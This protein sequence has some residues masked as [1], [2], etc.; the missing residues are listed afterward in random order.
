MT[1]TLRIENLSES[2]PAVSGFEPP[3]KGSS[4]R[5]SHPSVDPA[6][7]W[8]RGARTFHLREQRERELGEADAICG[9]IKHVRVAEREIP[10]GAKPV[11][12]RKYQGQESVVR[13]Q[14]LRGGGAGKRIALVRFFERI[15]TE[16]LFPI[17]G[18]RATRLLTQIHT[19]DLQTE[20]FSYTS[21]RT[22]RRGK[23]I[24]K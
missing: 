6:R 5:L 12:R 21:G 7:D 16:N 24:Q 1:W 2:P 23:Q 14:K 22:I 20:H 18:D 19:G 11:G 3:P 15:A 8:N 10:R 17:L 4:A 13:W 9:P